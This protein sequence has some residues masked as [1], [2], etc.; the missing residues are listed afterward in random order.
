MIVSHRILFEITPPV[1]RLLFQVQDASATI[2]ADKRYKGIIDILVRVPKEQGF[3]A[4]WRGNL[5]NV[6]RYVSSF[7]STKEISIVP[8]TSQPKQSIS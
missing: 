7:K 2:T 8:D 6:L 3:M 5:A 4:L 1:F